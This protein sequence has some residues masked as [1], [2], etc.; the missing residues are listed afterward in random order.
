MVINKLQFLRQE[1]KKDN[2]G[3]VKTK[4]IYMFKMEDL[5]SLHTFEARHPHKDFRD[6]VYPRHLH[7]AVEAKQKVILFFMVHG[8]YKNRARLH[9]LTKADQMIHFVITQIAVRKLYYRT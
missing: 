7:P 6:L 2:L 5:A 8:I 4:S 9:D 3:A 1:V